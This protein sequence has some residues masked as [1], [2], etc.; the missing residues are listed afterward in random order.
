[1]ESVSRTGF[2]VRPD[3]NYPTRLILPDECKQGVVDRLQNH[4]FR[5]E[6]QSGYRKGYYPLYILKE[7]L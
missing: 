6:A 2:D 5:L 1:M 3:F 7:H 4:I